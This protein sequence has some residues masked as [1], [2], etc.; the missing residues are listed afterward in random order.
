MILVTFLG[1]YLGAKMYVTSIAQK[2]VDEAIAK[3]ISFVDFDYEDVS[4]DLLGM[5]LHINGVEITSVDSK[6]KILV[7][8]IIVYKME[9]DS[10]GFPFELS[11]EFN[12]I[13]LNTKKSG[14]NTEI[15]ESL[16]YDDKMLANLSVDY[17]YKSEEKEVH[18]KKISAGVDDVGEL[19][20]SLSLGN[21]SLGKDELVMLMFTFPQIT[22]LEAQVKYSDDSLFK[23][24]VKAEAKKKNISV[25]EMMQQ[26]NES[27]KINIE[28]EK[29]EMA[30]D[31]MIKALEFVNSP[32][33]FSVSAEPSNPQ[34]L[35]RIMRTK[36]NKDL[37]K[38]LNVLI[39]S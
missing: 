9:E 6:N 13:N 11:M 31:A 1:G 16:G 37:I 39:K 27:A 17:L 21:I 12:G 20:L 24:W 28:A 36:E 7:N 15:L 8:E 5:N 10:L 18:F 3:S 14:L 29:D 19:S 34:P 33:S 22:L 4:V 38:M 30:K 23:R 32:K 25:Q 2:K 35:G 26:M